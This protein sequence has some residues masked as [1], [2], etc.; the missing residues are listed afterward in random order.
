MGCPLAGLSRAGEKPVR[1]IEMECYTA[2]DSGEQMIFSDDLLGEIALTQM[3]AS[4]EIVIKT[5]HSIYL[6]AVISPR[7]GI[8]ILSG[9]TLGDEQLEAVLVGSVDGVTRGD[10]DGFDG[11]KTGTRAVFFVFDSSGT[12]RV[13]TSEITRL[14]FV[15]TGD[16]PQLVA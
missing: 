2:T 12:K 5:R 3:A 10:V 13:I 1:E 7:A 9:G 11:L 8:G 6:F 4:D 16:D 15:R 14:T